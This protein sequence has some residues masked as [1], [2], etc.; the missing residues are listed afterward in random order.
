MICIYYLSI[1]WHRNRYF[2]IS[3]GLHSWSSNSAVFAT[4][5]ITYL[6]L[7]ISQHLQPE[8]HNFSDRQRIKWHK[9]ASETNTSIKSI[10]VVFLF[11]WTICN[12]QLV[13]S[14]FYRMVWFFGQNTSFFWPQKL[15]LPKTCFKQCGEPLQHTHISFMP[16]WRSAAV[17][18]VSAS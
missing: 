4:E 18:C 13:A 15:N 7:Q 8:R 12:I 5:V 9:S 1:N 2:S 6:L 3:F 14:H 10:R 11:L 17:C 16:F